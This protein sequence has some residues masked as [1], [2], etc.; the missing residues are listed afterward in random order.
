MPQ[1]ATCQHSR[2]S[3][4]PRALQ[5]AAARVLTEPQ[6]CCQV[7][8]CTSHLPSKALLRCTALLTFRCLATCA[9]CPPA[10]QAWAE[11]RLRAFT[12]DASLHV[13][14][15]SQQ[16]VSPRRPLVGI[17]QLLAAHKAAAAAAVVPGSEAAANPAGDAPAG[18]QLSWADLDIQRLLML[19]PRLLLVREW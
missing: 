15:G 12:S 16:P 11:G 4:V 18:G 13:Q 10:L 9:G 8:C 6:L 19:D 3:L 14:R 17:R 5:F 2:A 1:A 7:I